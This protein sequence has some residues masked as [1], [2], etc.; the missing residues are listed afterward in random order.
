ME[1]QELYN[2]IGRGR[3]KLA[4]A[5]SLVVATSFGIS[6]GAA[7]GLRARSAERDVPPA[8]EVL[9]ASTELPRGE[10]ATV[11]APLA[12]VSGAADLSAVTAKS[13][14]VYDSKT[15]QVLFERNSDEPVA[16]A[17]L[18]KLMT[19]LVA[20]EHATMDERVT[21][22]KDLSDPIAPS[23][24]L[25]AGDSVA[26]GDLVQAM[27]VG[28]CN[29]AAEL[30]GRYVQQKTGTSFVRLMNDRA[31]SLGMG[32]TVFAN[33]TGFP[34]SRAHSTARDLEILIGE[35]QKYAL[36]TNL[37]RTLSF[38]FRGERGTTYR[39]VASNKLL[40]GRPELIAIKTGYTNEAGGMMAVQVA[41]QGS[42]RATIIVL[43]S[44]NRES[45]TLKLA[46]AVKQNVAWN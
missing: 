39:T 29:D 26:L 33:A 14:L 8:G 38:R 13:F 3:G 35:T 18:T 16:I 10:E 1:R 27:L 19:A 4:V 32:D 20:Y 7:A 24:W 15:G 42:H 30:I 5:L 28:S 43:S 9:G 2:L 23:L 22:P 34:N 40:R 17:S 31:A 11:V 21:V 46:A 36:F 12:Q 41:G 37:G 6:M 45:D 44:D 25:K